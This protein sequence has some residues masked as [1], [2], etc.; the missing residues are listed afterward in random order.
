MLYIARGKPRAVAESAA[1]SAG[2]ARAIQR[3]AGQACRRPDDRT[4]VRGGVFTCRAQPKLYFLMSG[5]RLEP[6]IQ[7]YQLPMAFNGQ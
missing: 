3:H 4:G 1:G 7:I 2:L 5:F 6:D